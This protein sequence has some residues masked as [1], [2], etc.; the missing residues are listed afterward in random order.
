MGLRQKNNEFN[1]YSVVSRFVFG[2]RERDHQFKHYLMMHLSRNFKGKILNYR[3]CVIVRNL[4][5]FYYS[6]YPHG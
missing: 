3:V 5:A 1:N 6:K 4:G 2:E